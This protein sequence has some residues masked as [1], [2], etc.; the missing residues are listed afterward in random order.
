VNIKN[1]MWFSQ[2][3]EIWWVDEDSLQYIA[4]KSGWKY[5]RADNNQTLSDIFDE[6]SQ[7]EKTDI[8]IETVETIQSKSSYFSYILWLL[9]LF[10]FIIK[11]RKKIFNR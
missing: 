5:F 2:Q 11:M 4:K 8:E 9:I 3:V 6:I 10:L 1:I 7:L